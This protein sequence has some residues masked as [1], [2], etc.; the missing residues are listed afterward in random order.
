MS[1]FDKV[2]S[3]YDDIFSH[4][5]IGQLQRAIVH[6]YLNDNITWPIERLLEIGCGTGEDLLYFET[7]A[8][9][10]DAFDLSEAMIEVASTKIDSPHLRI[11]QKDL[12]QWI[13][14]PGH[15]KYDLIF[16]NFGVLN[17]LN[18]AHF[19]DFHIQCSK[20]LKPGGSLILVI[21]PSDCLLEKLYFL[22]K[23]K[24]SE[25]NRRSS[26]DPNV[27]LIEGSPQPTWYHNPDS[28]RK[29]FP[30]FRCR[31][32]QPIG[33]A[34]PPSYLQGFFEQRPVWLKNLTFIDQRLRKWSHLSRFADHFLIH[35][36]KK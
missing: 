16:S 1:S 22:L 6:E 27:V 19:Q 33:L 3:T 36:V 4:S 25:I 29:H 28:I 34:I 7:R 8:K 13:T 18:R 23:G 35:L 5:S 31:K 9:Q 26:S 32:L 24:W 21:M 20:T 15:K 17:C 12:R 2:A 14:E 10:I 11:V 30:D